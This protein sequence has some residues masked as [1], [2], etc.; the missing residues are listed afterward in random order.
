MV[1]GECVTQLRGGLEEIVTPSEWVTCQRVEMIFLQGAGTVQRGGQSSFGGAGTFIRN[2]EQHPWTC[3]R[4]VRRA[5]TPLTQGQM[6]AV[7]V[8]PDSGW[9]TCVFLFYLNFVSEILWIF[10]AISR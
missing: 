8:L 5:G 7:E 4:S 1:I 6:L 9:N 2:L 3:C 10:G